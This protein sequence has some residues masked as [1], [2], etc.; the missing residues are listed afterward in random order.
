MCNQYSWI[1]KKI[2]QTF[3][4]YSTL[5]YNSLVA[6]RGNV[7][8]ICMI[9]LSLWDSLFMG[10]IQAMCIVNFSTINYNLS[11][12][13]FVASS[14]FGRKPSC[15]C[16]ITLSCQSMSGLGGHFAHEIE[17]SWLFHS[18]ISHRPKRPTPSMFTSHLEGECQRPKESIMNTKICM[19][20]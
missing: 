11:K 9:F 7:Y 12:F 15:N 10:S 17:S 3:S 16:L 4:S 6:F 2:Q 18:K 19:G 1:V 20:S 5:K 13:V 14:F 8:H